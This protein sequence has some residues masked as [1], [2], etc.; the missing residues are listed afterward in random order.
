MSGGSPLTCGCSRVSAAYNNLYRALRRY[1][2]RG[3]DIDEISSL[4]RL[5]KSERHTC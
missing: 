3:I 4:K 1:V 5:V 2:P